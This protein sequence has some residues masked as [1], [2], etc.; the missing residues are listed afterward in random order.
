MLEPRLVNMDFEATTGRYDRSVLG[1][2]F[3][4][5][6]KIQTSTLTGITQGRSDSLQ[7]RSSPYSGALV[8]VTSL[9]DDK[10]DAASVYP[11]NETYSQSEVNT[12]PR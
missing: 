4:V 7:L 2:S 10:A 1:G 9:N 6:I 12:Y 5:S 3:V 11:K 8:E